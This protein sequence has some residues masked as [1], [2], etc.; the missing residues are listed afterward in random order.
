LLDT[1]VLIAEES[2]RPLDGEQVP[3]QLAISAITIGELQAGV[4]ATADIAVRARR[5][6]TLQVVADVAV[7]PVDEAVAASWA[8]LRVE[9][10][11]AGRRID[12]NDLWIAATAHAHG[13]AVVTQ[14]A[15]F[16]PVEG[17]AGLV[18]LRV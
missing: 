4:L 3:E 12:V 15:D 5:L 10:A 16:E 9:L 1:S 18:V 8:V 6:A 11:A 17:L 7:L 13:I 14:D 2:G